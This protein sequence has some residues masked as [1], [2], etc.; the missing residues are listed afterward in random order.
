M[1]SDEE[2]RWLVTGLVLNKVLLPHILSKVEQDVKTE[3]NKLVSSHH[4]DTQPS[5]GRLTR[6][7]VFLKYENIN[8]NDARKLSSGK[9]DYK[10]FIYHVTSHVDF[11]RL[12]LQPYMAKFS[13][14]DE[15]D[16]SAVLTLLGSVP[17]FSAATKSAA[18][19][20]K[21]NVR[22]EWAHCDFSQWTEAFFKNCFT[23]MDVLVTSLGLAN[24]HK[25][26]SE[27]KDWE[28]KGKLN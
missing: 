18:D 7:G 10:S 22:N 14:F 15:C 3:Y 25:V 28:S 9:P 6:H 16:A 24:T 2:K 27:L 20:V 13:K 17:V 4:I 11:A 1:V 23:D 8:G 21:Q 5:A 26:T 12:Y 19:K